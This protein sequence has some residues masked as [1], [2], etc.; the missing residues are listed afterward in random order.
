[1]V[2]AIQLGVT[3]TNEVTILNEENEV[4]LTAM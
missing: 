3:S 4:L 1:M 2:E